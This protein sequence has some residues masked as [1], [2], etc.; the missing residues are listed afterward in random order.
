MKLTHTE[1][2]FDNKKTKQLKSY[3]PFDVGASSEF[4]DPKLH[5][6]VDHFDIVSRESNADGVRLRMRVY[7]T[8]SKIANLAQDLSSINTSI[9]GKENKIANG[10]V[11]QYFR[12]D[13]NWEIGRAHV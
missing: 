9:G 7:V 5:H 10:T 6:G 1:D 12:G 13:K 3:K 11:T 4:Y 8:Q 2:M